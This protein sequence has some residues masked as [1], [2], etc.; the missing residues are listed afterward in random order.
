MLGLVLVISGLHTSVA[1]WRLH[2]YLHEQMYKEAQHIADAGS[3]L[4]GPSVA[5]ELHNQSH[6][7][8]SLADFLTPQLKL[9]R[10]LNRPNYVSI[11]NVFVLLRVP[12]SLSVWPPR[13]TSEQRGDRFHRPRGGNHKRDD[14]AVTQLVRID[15][16]VAEPKQNDNREILTF[17]PIVDRSGKEIARLGVKAFPNFHPVL[18]EMQPSVVVPFGLTA[19]L[20]V[21]LLA[22]DLSGP[23]HEL[24]KM[25][26]A[27]GKGETKTEF[28]VIR[29]ATFSRQTAV[30]KVMAAGLSERDTMKQLL[31]SYVSRQLVEK[32]M[33]KGGLPALAGERRE[34]TVLFADIRGFTSLSEEMVPEELVEL[35]NEFFRRMVEVIL[36][37][38]GTIDKFLGDGMMVIFGAPFDD[39]RHQEHSVRAAL[40]MQRELRNLA[41]KWELIGPNAVKMGIG[42]NSGSAIVGHVGSE[43]HME[44]TAIGDAVNVASRLQSLTKDLG[45]DIIVSESTYAAVRSLFQWKDTGV[46]QVRGRNQAVRSY[47]V[48]GIKE[49]S[50][51]PQVAPGDGVGEPR[52]DVRVNRLPARSFVPV[53]S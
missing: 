49:I 24:C 45:T 4:I 22:L 9:L 7:V 33:A 39:V 40:E 52:L 14:A 28:S 46:L 34:I 12:R 21:A 19:M 5:E 20:L 37:N 25:I 27:I 16:G 13:E 41:P 26:D 42:I 53:E 36:R 48:E 44:Y 29:R 30:L 2:A 6:R 32:I 31:S 1:Y 15:D 3:T 43:E 18:A 35:L 47:C 8:S 11:R 10:S 51:G 17:A 38:H 50:R 23:V